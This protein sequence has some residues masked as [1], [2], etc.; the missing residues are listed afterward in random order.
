MERMGHIKGDGLGSKTKGIVDPINPLSQHNKHGLGFTPAEFDFD[1]STSFVQKN[2]TSSY[3]TTPTIAND[4]R[5]HQALRSSE[6]HDKIDGGVQK[7]FGDH[8]E[9]D[10][11]CTSDTN[12]Q[13]NKPLQL[14]SSKEPISSIDSSTAAH[15]TETET[16]SNTNE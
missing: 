4:Q 5:V 12:R 16:D 15:G 14:E 6:G 8:L 1:G 13:A 2:C 11:S 10:Q 7:G 3:P 9:M